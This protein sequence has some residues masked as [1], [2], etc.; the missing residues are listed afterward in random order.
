[1][2]LFLCGMTTASPQIFL[3]REREKENDLRLLQED[4]SFFFFF[5]RCFLLKLL[6][7]CVIVL[8]L[9]TAK[10]ITGKKYKLTSKQQRENY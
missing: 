1:L 3:E 2:F 7:C 8:Y 4:F 6:Q 9:S 5:R 10:G